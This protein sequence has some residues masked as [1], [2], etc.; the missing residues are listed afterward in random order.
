MIQTDFLRSDRRALTSPHVAFFAS[1][2]QLLCYLFSFLSISLSLSFLSIHTHTRLGWKMDYFPMIYICT[3]IDEKWTTLFG[4]LSICACLPAIICCVVVRIVR[5]SSALKT[6]EM[7]T[8]HW[9]IC[10]A[11]TLSEWMNTVDFCQFISLWVVK[12]MER[13]NNYKMKKKTMLITGERYIRMSLVVGVRW[14]EPEKNM[15][16]R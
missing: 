4:F 6:I 1:M 5:R 10:L 11:E 7:C 3:F 15:P 2:L 13:R 9:F 12:W 14:W 8:G 16:Y